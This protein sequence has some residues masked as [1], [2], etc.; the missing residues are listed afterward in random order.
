MNPDEYEKLL[1]IDHSHW[2]YRGKRDIVR[3][4][5][6][7]FIKLTP[8]DLLI[9]AGMGTGTWAVEMAAR[10]RVIGLDDHDES[11]ALAAPRVEAAGGQVMKSGLRAIGLPSGVATVVT[12]MDVL[13]HVDDDAGALREMIRLTRPG[14]LLV[15][16]V[17]AFRCL[18]SDWDEAMHHR[19]RYTKRQ[20]LRAVRQ[21]GVRVLRCAYFN[22]AMFLPI[23]FVR[24][25]RRIRPAKAATERSEDW[26]PPRFLNR[27]LHGLLVYPACCNF[28]PAP[29]GVSLLAVLQRTAG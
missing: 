20:L 23:A 26:I 3:H 29:V 11:L 12:L 1:Q 18:W 5:I 9:D 15:V 16:T 27:T 25:Y 21:P 6:G 10:C 17:P 4:W 8:D 7:R 28:T 14:G 2:F 13:E 22:T 24:W 19:R